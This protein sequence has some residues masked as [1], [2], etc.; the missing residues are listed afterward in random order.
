MRNGWG[1]HMTTLITIVGVEEAERRSV[2]TTYKFSS[3]AI[4]RRHDQHVQ[5]TARGAGHARPPGAE[6][7]A[8]GGRGR[9]PGRSITAPPAASPMTWPPGS[10][11][12]R[13]PSETDPI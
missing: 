13:F 1:M 9:G 5:D 12:M 8:A 7:A 4:P 3:S 6:M 11:T 2:R 10:E